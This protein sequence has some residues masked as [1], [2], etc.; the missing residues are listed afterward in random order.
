MKKINKFHRLLLVFAL[1]FWALSI[2]P[3]NAQIGFDDDVDDEV[4]GA[5]IDGFIGLGLA[6]GAYFG[7]RKLKGK[8]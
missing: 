1:G 5:P 6:A 7:Y 8:V 4:P 2:Q 3:A